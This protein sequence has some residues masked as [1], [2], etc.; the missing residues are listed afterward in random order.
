MRCW[1]KSSSHLTLEEYPTVREAKILLHRLF[2]GIAKPFEPLNIIQDHMYIILKVLYPFHY[3]LS[4]CTPI[5]IHIPASIKNHV[6]LLHH[7]RTPKHSSQPFFIPQPPSYLPNPQPHTYKHLHIHECHPCLVVVAISLLNLYDARPARC[8][9]KIPFEKPRRRCLR[10]TM[11]G[12]GFPCP[13]TP[14]TIIAVDNISTSIYPTPKVKD[15]LSLA[16]HLLPH[17]CSFTH[18][19]C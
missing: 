4:P 15:L 3:T 12:A 9:F 13:Q 18:E 1:F 14:D 10:N 8:W 7:T 19:S 5:R 16:E 6:V 11:H 2:G 17:A